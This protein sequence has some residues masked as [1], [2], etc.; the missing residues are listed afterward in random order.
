[1]LIEAFDR[2]VANFPNAKLIIG[3]GNHPK[4]PGYMESMAQRYRND[5]ITFLGYVPEESIA[6]LFRTASLTVMPYTSSAG[7][8]GVAHLAAQYGVPCIASDIQDFRELAEHEGIAIRFFKSG[9]V[10]S[11]VERLL[12]ALNSPD[13]LQQ[14]AWQSYSAGISMSMPVVVR[15][16]IRSF[17]QRERIKVLQLASDLRRAGSSQQPDNLARMV[18]EKIQKWPEEDQNANSWA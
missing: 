1:L 9:N 14:M 8:S 15:E 3:G 12:Q 17:Q 16:Y 4:A 6:D 2:V 11:L 18:G 5:R 10:E 13:E 7:S